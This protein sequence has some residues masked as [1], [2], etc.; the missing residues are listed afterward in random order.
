MRLE[1]SLLICFASAPIALASQEPSAGA[2]AMPVLEQLQKA[3]LPSTEKE[4][5]QRALTRKDYLTVEQVLVRAIE[6]D[7][8]AADLLTLA[9]RVFLL[10]RNPGNAAIAL[11][12]AEKLRPLS[13]A[14]RFQLV[15]AYIGLKRGEWARPELDRLAATSPQNQLYP[16]WLARIDYD[17]RNYQSSIARLRSVTSANPAFMRA[18][19]NLG[20]SLEAMG[21]LDEAIDSYRRAVNLNRDQ[22]PSS[23]WPPLNLGSLLTKLDRLKEAEA[24]LGESLGYGPNLAE[25]HY[26]LGVNLH[27]Q[28]NDD[29]AIAELKQATKLD[30]TSAE[31]LYALGQVYRGR[32]DIK[33]SDEAF[34]R[35]KAL[36]KEK[37]GPP[38]PGL[39]SGNQHLAP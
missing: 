39:H 22:K 3:P 15:M 34:A 31:P 1:I 37:R 38:A 23:P 4:Q 25:A 24:A 19:D 30:P 13:E 33:A 17:E 16:Y 18:W 10:D 32:G 11:K 5:A 21:Q 14:D 27:R 2:P 8:K 35:Y 20:L 26:R 9:A 12:K 7:A 6:A 28:G 29:S 36:K